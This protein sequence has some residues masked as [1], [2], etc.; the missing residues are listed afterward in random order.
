MQSIFSENEN[1]YQ[2]YYVSSYFRK[3]KTNYD[4]LNKLAPSQSS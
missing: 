1:A 2:Y 3:Y 4:Q